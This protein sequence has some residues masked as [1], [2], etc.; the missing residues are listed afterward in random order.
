MVEHRRP[1][2][3]DPGNAG[4][5]KKLNKVVTSET[6]ILAEGAIFVALSVILKD[7]LPPI[8]QLPQGGSV[9]AAGMVPLLWF[10]LRRGLRSGLEASGLRF[11][12]YGFAW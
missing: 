9:S 3:P 5:G 8:F 1:F 7:V 2:E 4:G 12:S 6:K 10:S 11:G